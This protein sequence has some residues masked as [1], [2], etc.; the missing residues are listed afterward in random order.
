MRASIVTR[1]AES[2]T[3]TVTT[4]GSDQSYF[5][6]LGVGGAVDDLEDVGVAALGLAAHAVS[7]DYVEVEDGWVAPSG[8]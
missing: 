7:R 6:Q 2:R 3:S 5:G 4:G 1:W 8:N